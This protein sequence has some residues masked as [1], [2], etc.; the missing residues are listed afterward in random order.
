MTA[1]PPQNVIHLG[2]CVEFMQTLPD[3]SVDF[4]C[5]DPPYGIDFGY[6]QHDDNF[7]GWKKLMAACIPEWHRIC[8][9]PIIFPSASLAGRRWLWQNYPPLWTLCWYKGSPGHA[10][11][12]GFNDWED[13]HVMGRN[14]HRHAHDHFYAKPTDAHIDWHPC[15]KSTEYAAWLVSR[16]SK[17]GDIVFDPF[18]GS[19]TIL[20]VAEQA[21][22]RWLG[23]EMSPNYHARIIARLALETAQG[24]LF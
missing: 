6:D 12:V 19:G 16:F 14:I 24:K 20:L 10:A 7:E 1:T 18:A 4:I 5:T 8:R 21:G 15:P 23:C 13:L 9:G 17:P 2:D 22:R 3:A 11:A